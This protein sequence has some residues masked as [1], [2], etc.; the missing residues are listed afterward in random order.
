M[1]GSISTRQGA[2]SG[3]F[4]FESFAPTEAG[5]YYVSAGRSLQHDF[6]PTATG[7]LGK[8]QKQANWTLRPL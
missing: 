5:I 6:I 7:W 3:H 2:P 4:T 1:G 8:T